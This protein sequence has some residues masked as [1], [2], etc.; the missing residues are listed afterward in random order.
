MS[1]WVTFRPNPRLYQCTSIGLLLLHEL[2]LCTLRPASKTGVLPKRSFSTAGLEGNWILD[3]S[4]RGPWCG[5]KS[6]LTAAI[7][8]ALMRH[9]L[10]EYEGP[11]IGMICVDFP[12]G[13]T[14]SQK[15]KVVIAYIEARP[16]RLHESFVDLALEALRAAWP[17]KP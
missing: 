15:I 12:P 1:A 17:C 14:N 8:A 3:G 16:A 13:V 2:T 6:R 4:A 5:Q 11:I 9:A 7:T 10:E